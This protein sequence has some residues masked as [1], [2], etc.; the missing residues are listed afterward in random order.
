MLFLS[1]IITS[2]IF[3]EKVKHLYRINLK[4]MISVQFRII[5]VMPFQPLFHQQNWYVK[6][7]F[8]KDTEFGSNWNLGDGFQHHANPELVQPATIS[9]ACLIHSPKTKVVFRNELTYFTEWIIS[10]VSNNPTLLSFVN[11]T[12]VFN[13]RCRMGFSLSKSKNWISMEILP[14]KVC[15]EQR[16]I[17]RYYYSQQCI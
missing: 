3:G 13:Q 14:G 12:N 8:E 9:M 1:S 15:T 4:L 11:S 7:S 10:S 5:L 16:N 2:L 17:L 6:A